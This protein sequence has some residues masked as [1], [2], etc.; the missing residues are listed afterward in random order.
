[1]MIVPEL[2]SLS[3]EH[4]R[5]F[6][7][8]TGALLAVSSTHI[9][10][11]LLV[12]AALTSVVND[13]LGLAAASL[14]GVAATATTRLILR[15]R[16]LHR[17][18]ELGRWVRHTMRS[19]V[20]RRILVPDR[21][22]D[23]RSRAGS[24]RLTA[25][26]AVDGVDAYLTR[27]LPQTVQVKL[28]CPAL[29]L[30]V[31]AFSPFAALLLG[32]FVLLAVIGPRAFNRWVSSRSHQRWESYDQLSSDFQ[33]SLQGMRTLH[34]L[35]AVPGRRRDL[36]ARSRRLHRET[37][38]VM[39]ASLWETGILDLMIQ[40]GT[41]VACVIAMLT[42]VDAAP[43]ALGTPVTAVQ[44]DPFRIFAVLM[45]ASETFRPVRDVS[46]QWHAGF[47]GLSAVGTLREHGA[48]DT[49]TVPDTTDKAEE[50]ERAETAQEAESA[51]VQP[52]GRDASSR[53]PAPGVLSLS[54]LT[55]Q[56]PR[57]VAPVLE[58]VN[59]EFHPAQISVVSGT[60][61]AGKST[62]FDVILGLLSPQSGEVTL[63]G[64]PVGAT[65]IAVV[66]Q[67]PSLFSTT[68]RENLTLAAPP[69]TSADEVLQVCDDAGL[70]ELIRTLPQGLDTPIAER[71]SSL[72]RGQAQRVAIARAYLAD[73]PVILM[74]E[75]TSALDEKNAAHVLTRLR[76]R[77][78]DRIVLIISHRDDV[79]EVADA[80]WHL[81]GGRLRRMTGRPGAR[82]SWEGAA[83]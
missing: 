7:R 76:E 38:R 34:L 35:G 44:D 2:V 73:R 5:S 17:A 81:E 31:A 83:R 56:Y 22:H 27:Y 82:Q 4:R 6:R 75:P 9:L 16:L 12:A 50:A 3:Q 30:A 55:H 47:L 72:S 28:L 10:Q 67:H 15:Q 8:V 1:M 20:L 42:A 64:R 52:T 13:R 46:Q 68:L 29:V 23:V 37:V 36:V 33:E 60:S 71:G 25:V 61:G 74:D 59:A 19:R 62:L 77:A 57:T 58:A 18:E 14:V 32:L 69:Q 78:A 21:L 41:A 70:T 66:S 80:R 79:G 49:E 65:E 48:F 24:A 54:E 51:E 39:R 26:D 40:A 45:L 11:A 53:W 43:G 63:A